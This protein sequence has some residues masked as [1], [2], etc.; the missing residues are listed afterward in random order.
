MPRVTSMDGV[1]VAYEIHDFTDPWSDAPTLILQHGFSRSARYWYHMIPH[2]ARNFRVV[3]PTLRGLGESGSDFDLDRGLTLENYLAD[4]NAIVDDLGVSSVHYSGESIGGI[5]GYAFAARFPS[6]VRTLCAL[7]APL[8]ITEEV[9][10]AFAF[11]YSSWDEA[12]MQLGSYEW[13]KKANSA[14]RFPPGTNPRLVDWYAAEAGK[15]RP[16]A[17]AAMARFAA[18]AN[19]TSLLERIEAPVLGLY[20]TTGQVTTNQQVETL[21]QKIRDFRIVHLPTTY[22]MVW[23]LYPAVCA[24]HIAHFIA[25]HEGVACV[26]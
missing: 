10:K 23:V 12:I 16:E 7:A 3:C 6:R 22:H 5:L 26:E 2:L 13:S 24:R 19:V 8:Y 17:M 9:K 4:L 25:T 14:T 20:P 1:S 21:K 15:N 18:G 11:G